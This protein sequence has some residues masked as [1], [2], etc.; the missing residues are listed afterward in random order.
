MD[1]KTRETGP[2]RKLHDL[3]R[4]VFKLHSTLSMVMDGVH[5]QAGL[6]T[7]QHRIMQTLRKMDSAT[8]PDMAFRLDVSRQFV[9]TVCNRLASMELIEFRDN[10]RHKRSK[11]VSLTDKGYAAYGTA[12]RKEDE[13]IGQALADI[14][15]A[16]ATQASKLLKDI[17]KAVM[18]CFTGQF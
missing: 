10:P 4:E 16:A 12:R 17:R 2:G 8:V 11:M 9:Q 5:E 6:S 3:F 1:N 14:D 13:I 7:A 15:T 18:D